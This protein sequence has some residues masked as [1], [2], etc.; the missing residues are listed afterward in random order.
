VIVKL[1]FVDDEPR[2]QD[3]VRDG[4]SDGVFEVRTCSSAEEAIDLESRESF[5]GFLLDV[6]LPGMSGVALCRWLRDQGHKEPIIMLTARGS[7]DDKVTG[8]ESGADDYLSKP[9]EVAE[10]R[11]R[12]R[13]MFRKVQGYPREPLVVEDLMLDPNTRKVTRAGTDLALS[14]KE[15]LLLEYLMKNQTRLVTRAMIAH[16]VW[17][18]DTNQYTNVIDVFINHLRK[19]VD[20]PG[21][22]KLLHT[23]R[24]K[25]FQLTSAPDREV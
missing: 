16:A 25:G 9:F 19:K 22:P 2:I 23:I 1:L 21:L 17:D 14:K 4:L 13:A 3:V 24:G 20:R 11:A 18:S 10:L 12:F 7:L 15:T 6:L 8:L 5:D